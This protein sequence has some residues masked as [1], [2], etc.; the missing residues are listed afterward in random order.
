MRILAV[1]DIHGRLEYI[2][3]IAA[4]LMQ[5]QA[6]LLVVAGDL[7]R[8]RRA[9]R[10]VLQLSQLP[11]P[12][13]CIR[14]NT[15]RANV[16]K[17]MGVYSDVHDLHLKEKTIGGIHFAGVGGTVPL[18]F[19]S[20]IR[21]RENAMLKKLA[22]SV[23]KDTILVAHPPPYGTLDRVLGK[24]HAGSRNLHHFLMRTQPRLLICGH[25]H[26]DRGIGQVGRT[27]V[28][29]CAMSRNYGGVLIELDIDKI[30]A[31]EIIKDR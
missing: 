14:G 25:V 5:F 11:V 20:R 8:Y 17:W 28:I 15:D 3:R 10:A 6:D 13:L 23:G 19:R 18:P 4:N 2:S 29:N 22:A 24:F 12:C 21:L 7:T 26:E 9:R 16:E 31:I 1:A 30:K 27:T